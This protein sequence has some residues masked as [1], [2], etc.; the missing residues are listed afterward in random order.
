M[1]EHWPDFKSEKRIDELPILEKSLDDDVQGK[2]GIPFIGVEK[3]P[4]RLIKCI[5]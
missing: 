2:K 3:P 1:E 5:Q 4:C